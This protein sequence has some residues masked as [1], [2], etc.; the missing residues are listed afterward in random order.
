M[1]PTLLNCSHIKCKLSHFYPLIIEL[2]RKV[3]VCK[4]YILY[5]GKEKTRLSDSYSN[6]VRI[7]IFIL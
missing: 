2:Y 5:L 4:V 1:L 6:P 7:L 3:Y